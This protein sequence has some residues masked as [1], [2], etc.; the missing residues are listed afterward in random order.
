MK[1]TYLFPIA[2]IALLA[3]AV[4]PAC[5]FTCIKGSGNHVSENHKVSDFTRINISGGFKVILKQ[6]S[7]LNVSVKT[8]DNL[9]KYVHVESDG[10]EL[11]IYVKKKICASGEMELTIGVRNLKRLKGSGA[12]NFIS[13]GKIN[14]KD[15]DIRLDGASNVDMDLTAA[16]VS[17]RTAGASEISLKGQA[18]SH[19]I[20]M[21][22]N[23]TVH[24]FDFVVGKYEIRTTGASDC[25][26]N[27][28]NDLSVNATGASDVKYKGSPTNVNTSK[29]G[30]ATVTHVN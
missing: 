7:S 9:A 28:L 12:I 27:V 13:D 2:F 19:H 30:A 23:G 1:K 8:D 18:T 21:T 20:E 5:R 3:I 15:L 4:L 6:D 29:L 11:K 26:I 10:D 17:T 22:G 16:N 25:E 14:T 24:A